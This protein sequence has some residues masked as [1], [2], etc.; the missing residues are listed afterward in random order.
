MRARSSRPFEP[1]AQIHTADTEDSGEERC[2]MPD[3]EWEEDVN[4]GAEMLIHK[5]NSDSE[6]PRLH[7]GSCPKINST[8]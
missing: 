5:C 4:N 3:P 8:S 7:L 2:L 1:E 6:N